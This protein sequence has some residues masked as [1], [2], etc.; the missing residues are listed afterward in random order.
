MVDADHSMVADIKSKHV[1]LEKGA[2]YKVS[3]PDNLSLVASCEL[4][5]TTPSA[6]P[7]VLVRPIQDPALV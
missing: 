7:V 5:P 2:T 6:S 1:I 4:I 3:E